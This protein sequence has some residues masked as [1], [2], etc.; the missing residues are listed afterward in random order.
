MC[1]TSEILKEIHRF[2]FQNNH[3]PR[4]RREHHLSRAASHVRRHEAGGGGHG[5]LHH[6]P[7]P[8]PQEPHCTPGPHLPGH[9]PEPLPPQVLSSA[10]QR[11]SSRLCVCHSRHYHGNASRPSGAAVKVAV[12]LAVVPSVINVP[13]CAACLYPR[14]LALTSALA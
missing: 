7:L 1:F 4:V 3:E 10:D 9:A 11:V 13:E 5:A 6:R 12:W 2:V 14:C 8:E